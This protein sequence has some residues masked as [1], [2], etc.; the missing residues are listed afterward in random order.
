MK[1]LYMYLHRYP[2]IQSIHPYN[3]RHVHMDLHIPRQCMYPPEKQVTVFMAKSQS[4]LFSH[5]Y[6]LQSQSHTC[7][8]ALIIMCLW[9]HLSVP[10]LQHRGTAKKNRLLYWGITAVELDL[11][12]FLPVTT[13]LQRRYKAVVYMFSAA[14]SQF[15]YKTSEELFEMIPRDQSIFLNI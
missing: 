12:L 4:Q 10:M 15:T 11:T 6:N 1:K 14:Q 5:R 3:N 2:H 9:L 13:V 8:A 7:G